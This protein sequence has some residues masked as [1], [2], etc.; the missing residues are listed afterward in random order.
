MNY[1]YLLRQIYDNPESQKEET[2][3][4]ENPYELDSREQKSVNL[5]YDLSVLN[6]SIPAQEIVEMV[7]NAIVNDRKSQG[8][9]KGIRILFYGLSGSGKTNLAHYI[10]DTIGK[11]LL[12]KN[13]SDILGMLVG[14]SEKNI[15]KAFEEAKKQKKILLFDEVDSFFRERSYASQSWEI[16]Q[17]NEFLTQMEKFEGIVICTTNLRNIMD[18]AMQRRFHIMVEF[19]ALKDEGVESLLGKYFPQF[20]FNEEDIKRIS[21]FQSAT[22][23]DFGNLSSRIRFMNQKKVTET[24][25]TDELCKM[26][27]EKELG[28]RSI[29][30]R[31]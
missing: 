4:I 12:C 9:E 10:A 2:T 19:K 1:Q 31:D 17:V 5:S 29:G 21:R 13:A 14:E 15:A 16:T 3:I 20:D 24:Y 28:K 8:K 30:F 6:T 22:L 27:E 18:K 11:K 26:Q 7:Q 23:G 25:I